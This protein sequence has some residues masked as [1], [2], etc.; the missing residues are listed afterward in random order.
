[1]ES[2]RWGSGSVRISFTREEL[3]E[4]TKAADD[5]HDYGERTGCILWARANGGVSD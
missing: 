2:K 5:R 3:A 1:M 4:M